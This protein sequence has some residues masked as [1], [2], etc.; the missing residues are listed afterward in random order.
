[1]THEELTHF[2]RLKGN[3]HKTRQSLFMPVLGSV[4]RPQLAC[5]VVEQM[6]DRNLSLTFPAMIMTQFGRE[7]P[8]VCTRSLCI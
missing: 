1:M 2:S 6:T 7:K 3:S 8:M 5:T 4:L